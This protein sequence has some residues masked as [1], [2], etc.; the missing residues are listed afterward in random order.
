VP[1]AFDPERTHLDLDQK[2]FA[3]FFFCT[4]NT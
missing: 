2:G 4:R 1:V 3:V